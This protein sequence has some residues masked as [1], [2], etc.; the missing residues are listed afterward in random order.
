M[1]TPPLTL[2]LLKNARLH[3]E[4]RTLTGANKQRFEETIPHIAS[5]CCANLSDV[6]DHAE[7]LL[8]GHQSAEATLA[9]AAARPE[10]RVIDLTRVSP[11]RAEQ[12]MP[13]AEPA[14]AR[15]VATP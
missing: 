4:P 10:Q 13:I 7:V 3:E 12:A 1:V 9:A 8:I 14:P 5:L 2:L 15:E 6:L 11:P